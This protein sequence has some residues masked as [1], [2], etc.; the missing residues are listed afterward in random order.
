MIVSLTN[1]TKT[2]SS[3]FYKDQCQQVMSLLKQA[4]LKGENNSMLLLARSKQ[5]MHSFINAISDDIRAELD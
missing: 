2:N 1:L 4:Y 3:D 5:T